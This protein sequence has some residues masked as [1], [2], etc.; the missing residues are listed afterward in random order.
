MDL[1]VDN[2]LQTATESAAALTT[3]QN[4]IGALNRAVQV[5]MV[6]T[7]LILMLRRMMSKLLLVVRGCNG[8]NNHNHMLMVD[9]EVAEVVLYL[10]VVDLRLLVHAVC[11][12]TILVMQP[13]VMMIVLVSPNS[14][15]PSLKVPLMWKN[16]L[17]GS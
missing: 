2:V 6:I 9:V 1:K 8:N 12:A 15:F 3:I 5:F 13:T 4:S 7:V 16:I 14:V 11:S 17:T 10:L